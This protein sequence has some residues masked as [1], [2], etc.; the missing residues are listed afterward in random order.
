MKDTEGEETFLRIQRA[1]EA[2]RDE[3]SRRR[4]DRELISHAGEQYGGLIN[5]EVDLDEMDYDEGEA[6]FRTEC[7]CGGEYI[8]TEQM[9]DEGADVVGCST[10]SLRIR[11]LYK[12]V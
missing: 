12:A 7:R 1:W 9:L 4:Y 10:C 5:A 2:L 11:V 6:T 8:V 3:D